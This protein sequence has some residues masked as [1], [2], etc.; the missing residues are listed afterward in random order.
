MCVVVCLKHGVDT[1]LELSKHSLEGYCSH[2]N[3]SKEACVE[4]GGRTNFSPTNTFAKRLS[5]HS[6][7]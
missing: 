6:F 4:A 3:R 1:I 2:D 5:K 7:D